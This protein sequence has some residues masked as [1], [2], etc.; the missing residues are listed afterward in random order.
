MRVVCH[1]NSLCVTAALGLKRG[2]ECKLFLRNLVWGEWARIRGEF[3][4]PKATTTGYKVHTK[5]EIW[6]SI[7]S[8][9]TPHT[10]ICI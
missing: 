6:L 7:V 2:S 1:R 10:L 4:Q 9:S 5:A 3:P 8:S